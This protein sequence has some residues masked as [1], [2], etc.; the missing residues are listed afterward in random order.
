MINEKKRSLKIET[1]AMVFIREVLNWICYVYLLGIFLVYPLFYQRRYFNMGEAKYSFYKSFTFIMLIFLAAGTA[2]YLIAGAKAI[3]WKS[4]YKKLSLPDW[5]A[6]LY[7]ITAFASALLSDY[8]ELAFQGSGGWYMGFYMQL[9]FVLLYFFISR[10]WKWDSTIIGV[11]CFVAAIAYFLGILHRFS[12][13]PL[14]L[15][16]GISEGQKV[17]FLSTLGQA[18]WYSS[19]L[20]VTFPL[21]L[22]F[23]WHCKKISYRIFGLIFTVL[24]FGTIVTQNS[25]SAFL[26]LGITMFVFFWFSMTSNEKF[27]RFLE[28]LLL[29]FVS[30]RI[31]G[32]LQVLFSSR[33]VELEKLSFFLSKSWLMWI[34]FVLLLLGYVL[35]VKAEKKKKINIRNYIG[36]RK[37]VLIAVLILIPAVI[38][39]I[40][41]VTSGILPESFKS[42]G[43]LNFNET[44]GNNRG[45][46][47]K[48]A[49]DM[50]LDFSPLR[51]LIGCGPDCF[52]GYGY[53]FF[54]ERIRAKWGNNILANAHNEWLNMLLTQGIIGLTVY[55][56]I[57]VSSVKLFFRKAEEIPFLTAIIACVAA[58][59]I[60]NAFCYQ[61]VIVTPIIFILMAIGY[62]IQLSGSGDLEEK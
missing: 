57:F 24:G 9:S 11:A 36:I 47:W 17:L 51:K 40:I 35:F 41:G 54:A 22:F 55:L 20:A 8:R 39:C 23:F 60:H 15:Y 16:N 56:G 53:E 19:Y 13:D 27:R 45:F 61:Q 4:L 5:F 29:M 58:Y 52:S 59:I 25:D 38:L 26:A 2:A 49:A 3:E 50:Y 48:L 43:Y 28:I 14:D 1:E 42:I 46:T 37:I 7:L 30:F 10:W 12:L 62:Q 44:W 34:P 6:V 33:V 32:I 21:G 18:T 31:I